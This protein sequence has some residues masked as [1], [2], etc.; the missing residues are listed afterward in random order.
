MNLE[1]LIEVDNLGWWL[2]GALMLAWCL[3][4]MNK[5]RP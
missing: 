1:T 4:F 3:W 2:A 5:K